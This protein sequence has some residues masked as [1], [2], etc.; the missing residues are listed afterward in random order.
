MNEPIDSSPV[1]SRFGMI[2][3]MPMRILP[4]QVNNPVLMN[5]AHS[6]G[7]PITDAAG[8]ACSRPARWM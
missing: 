7:M 8:S 6:V 1:P 4:G 3:S 2:I 5:G